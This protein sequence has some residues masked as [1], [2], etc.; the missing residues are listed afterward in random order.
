MNPK[1]DGISF[2]EK[3]NEGTNEETSWNNMEKGIEFIF[4][5]TL[6]FILFLLAIV[7][8][9]KWYECLLAVVETQ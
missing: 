7:V 5:Q 4:D 2:D 3:G 6:T 8:G 9:T 1:G